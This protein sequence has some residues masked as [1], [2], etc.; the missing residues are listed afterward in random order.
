MSCGNNDKGFGFALIVW[1]IVATVR[2][3]LCGVSL[4]LN[5]SVAGNFSY[6][7]WPLVALTRRSD[8]VDL[9]RLDHG[10]LR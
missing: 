2:S 10:L 9:P 6:I 5:A 8:T 3:Y 1:F 4:I 7:Q